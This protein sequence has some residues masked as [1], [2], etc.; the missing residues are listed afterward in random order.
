M[1]NMSL[2]AAQKQEDI[3]PT[4][5]WGKWLW[6]TID[7]ISDL[8]GAFIGWLMLGVAFINCYEILM[9]K[10]FNAPTDWVQD[11]SIYIMIW[12][13]FVTAG[14]TW[15]K[16]K[17]IRVDL[18]TN[19]FTP[20]SRKALELATSLFALAYAVLLAAG[21]WQLAGLSL[22]RGQVTP[23]SLHLPVWLIQSGIVLGSAILA[24]QIIRQIA[25]DIDV[26]YRMPSPKWAN[27][28]PVLI[29][30]ALVVIAIGLVAFNPIAGLI[31][32]LFIMLSGG[33]PVFASLGLVGA[34]G[35]FLL[36][37]GAPSLAQV[38]FIGYKAMNEFILLAL[39]LFVLGGGL[40]MSGGMGK[41]LFDLCAKW[42]AHLPGG[43]AV[44][45][46]FACAIFAAI[47]GSSVATAATI[48]MIAIPAMLSRNYDRRL[49]Y[50]CVAA[51]GTLGILIPPSTPMIVYS[52]I[53]DESTG[54]L[55]IGGV[56]PGLLLVLI[57]A[58]WAVLQSKRSGSYEK[59][60]PA[61]MKE[62]MIALRD[63]AWGMLA[64]VM[65][66]G[67]IYT[68]L[69]TP[70]E[71]AAALVLYAFLVGVLRGRI[72]PGN[73][74]GVVAEGTTSAGMIMIIIAGAVVMGTVFT[75]LQ[76]PGMLSGAVAGSGLNPWWVIAAI[77][78][79]MIFL[80]MILEVA[81]ILL[82]TIPIFYP[83]ITALGFNGIW[84]CILVVVNM[85][86][87]LITPPVGLNLF[88]ISGIERSA[89][90]AEVVRGVAPFIVI[91]ALFLILLC[92]FPLLATWLPGSMGYKF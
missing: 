54:A 46:L 56:I 2:A 69:F 83:L 84:F 29:F 60:A 45:T 59:V 7:K 85:E 78:L 22:A 92:F 71:S 25:A 15:K 82:I 27:W 75:Q 23:N 57:M 26:F 43:L 72:K 44:A 50:G 52:A 4:P 62:K 39:P 21:G 48:G 86:M 28:L 79:L 73:I 14:Y 35:F 17:H 68:G 80:G 8:S 76:L 87:A 31:L 67:G 19:H 66:L 58:A 55:F 1:Q 9:R 89:K 88:V 51:G 20:A 16:G 12:F 41:E 61:T 32:L 40:M 6:V 70:A 3:L 81:S 34:A 33:I 5:R 47:S 42:V 36:F 18:L 74:S 77:M 30:I 38:P 65:I 49:A 64:P 91:M 11:I 37:G 63:G 90:L 10:F 13:A 24:L 53:T